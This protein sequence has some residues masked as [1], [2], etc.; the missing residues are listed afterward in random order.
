MELENRG[1]RTFT[2]VTDAFL[3]LAQAEAQAKGT[4][5]RFIVVKHPVGGLNLQELQTRAEQGIQQIAEWEKNNNRGVSAKAKEQQLPLIL[6]DENLSEGNWFEFAEDKGFGDGLPVAMPIVAKVHQ[7]LENSHCQEGAFAFTPIP[8]RWVLPAWESLAANAV[9]AGC[10]P[11]YFATVLTALQ[12]TL[13]EK[14][15]LFGVLATT[16]PCTPMMLVSGPKRVELEMNCQGNSLGQGTRSNATMGRALHMMMVNLGGA[17]PKGMDK[18]TFGAPTKFS[19]CLAENEE[20]SP[21]LPYHVRQG[22]RREDSVV[23]VAAAEPPHNINDHGS[24]SAD[25]LVTTIASTMSTAGNNNLY[26]GGEHFVVLGPE[27]A[28]TIHRDGWSIEQIQDALYE[29]SRVHVAR[30]SNGNRRHFEEVGKK[31]IG[32]YYYLGECPKDIQILV[33]GGYGK[34]SNWIPTFG[35]SRMVSQVIRG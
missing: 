22:F 23:T 28:Q 19:Y 32:E 11:E 18:A 7:F 30:I 9:M 10:K 12:A 25:E 33:S 31:P 6:Q 35:A 8:P 2:I 29:R 1:V 3:P 34:H 26:L 20:D 24:T 5:L 4:A 17:V 14:F 16:H 21:W 27:H 15:N 13:Q